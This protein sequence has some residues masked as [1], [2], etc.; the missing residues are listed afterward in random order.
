M[1][2][3]FV[4]ADEASRREFERVVERMMEESLGAEVARRLLRR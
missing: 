2:I 4:F 3:R 1:G